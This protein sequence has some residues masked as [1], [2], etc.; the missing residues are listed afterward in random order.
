[1]TTQLDLKKSTIKNIQ[2]K[3]KKLKNI[4]QRTIAK[5]MGGVIDWGYLLNAADGQKLRIGINELKEL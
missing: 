2:K 4:S 3:D 1:M 5:K